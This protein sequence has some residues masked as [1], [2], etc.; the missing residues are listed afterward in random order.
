MSVRQYIGARYVPKFYE[1]S[2]GNKWDNGVPYEP[3]TIVTYLLNS[4]TSKKT[5]PAAVGNPADNPDYWVCT[6]MFNAQLSQLS[7]DV[8][9]LD[10]TVSGLVSDVNDL[11]NRTDILESYTSKKT[12]S[13]KFIFVGDSYG[14][15]SGTNDGWIDK[16]IPLLGLTSDDYYETAVGGAGFT[17]NT[18]S[19]LSIFQTLS[20]SVTNKSEITDIVVL[21]GANDSGYSP[22]EIA[23]FVD[24]FTTYAYANYPNAI[25]S[26]GFISGTNSGQLR[27]VQ[28]TRTIAGYSQ[29]KGV[30]LNNL[31]YV[32]H[33][34][35]LMGSDGVHPNNDGYNALAKHIVGAL[36]GGTSVNEFY[37]SYGVNPTLFPA[38]TG[39]TWESGMSRGVVEFKDGITQILFKSKLD[40]EFST[41]IAITYNS[42]TPL[43]EIDVPYI[44][45]GY[46][47]YISNDV[48]AQVH[49][50]INNTWYLLPGFITILTDSN[51][52][53]TIY[54]VCTDQV[55]LNS[56]SAM[57]SVDRII[58]NPQSFSFYT[59][60]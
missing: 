32:L 34:L 47:T 5:V 16:I 56:T 33:N 13:R 12:G 1:G 27:D 10:D 59:C 49:S 21:G 60:M 29:V 18:N 25:V 41:P 28:Y 57:N 55:T 23:A 7:S 24:A 15:A 58:I 14:H 9:T 39:A 37:N 46:I 53:N 44:M 20:A 26:V 31:Q 40:F 22:D 4:Y 35:D 19:F 30:F 38:V 3:L 8:G 43:C 17:T 51:G 6:G 52:V 45:S 48:V 42:T 11:D 54:Y 2:N 36:L 50:S